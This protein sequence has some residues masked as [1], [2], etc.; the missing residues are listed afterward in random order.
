MKNKL[1]NFYELISDAEAKLALNEDEH[2]TQVWSREREEQLQIYE[3]CLA[4]IDSYFNE[5]LI[6]EKRNETSRL[7][8]LEEKK[9]R[10]NEQRE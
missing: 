7:E 9:R 6:E 3:D 10:E 8:E 2:E 5:I 4:D 1:E